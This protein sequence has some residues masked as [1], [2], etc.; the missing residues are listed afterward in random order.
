MKKW[1]TYADLIAENFTIVN[2]DKEEVPFVLNKA[3][4]HFLEN[5]TDRNTILKARKMGFSSITGR[6]LY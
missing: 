5:S 2:K 1:Q 3:Q 4:I 6:S